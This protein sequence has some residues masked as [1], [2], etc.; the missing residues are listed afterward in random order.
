MREGQ[1][2]EGMFKG[3]IIMIVHGRVRREVRASRNWAIVKG[4]RTNGLE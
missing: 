2:V 3:M 4:G 1:G